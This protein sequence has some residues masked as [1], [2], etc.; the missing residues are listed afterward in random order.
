MIVQERSL[1]VEI[2]WDLSGQRFPHVRLWQAHPI[3]ET[4]DDDDYRCHFLGWGDGSEVEECLGGRLGASEVVVACLGG[5]GWY[6][7]HM[8]EYP[9]RSVDV[10]AHVA[11]GLLAAAQ[12][13]RRD[14]V[15]AAK[16]LIGR[17]GSVLHC[18]GSSDARCRSRSVQ[19]EDEAE[20]EMWCRVNGPETYDQSWVLSWGAPS[21]QDSADCW[22]LPDGFD[23]VGTLRRLRAMAARGRCAGGRYHY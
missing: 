12:R 1:K 10:A 16:E 4:G 23:L 21:S 18:A 15:H 19:H 13:A 17:D 6:L 3:E 20:G 11:S 5:D 22:L 14:A 8:Q 2:A 7:Q 9:D